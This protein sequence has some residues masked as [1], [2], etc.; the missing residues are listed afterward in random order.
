VQRAG[1]PAALPLTASTNYN[2]FVAQNVVAGHTYE[3]VMRGFFTGTVVTTMALSFDVVGATC[4]S[5][6]RSAYRTSASPASG[7][8]VAAVDF[9]TT[10]GVGT[11]LNTTTAFQ[12]VG[13]FVCTA[14]GTIRFKV[15]PGTTGGTLVAGA[16]IE[17]KDV[18]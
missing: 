17:L 18:T 1:S 7:N 10:S 2:P 16:N 3:Y 6:T 11:V 13:H 14:S 8:I 4:S 12:M 15:N 9:S 5:H